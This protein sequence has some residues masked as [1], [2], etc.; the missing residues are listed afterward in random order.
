MLESNYD[1]VLNGQASRLVG[2]ARTATGVNS[3]SPGDNLGLS[4]NSCADAVAG[5][6]Q[7]DL[8][9]INAKNP[10]NLSGNAQVDEV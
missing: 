1:Y 10:E 2:H 3:L 4:V 6:L 5:E 7:G 9:K 8:G